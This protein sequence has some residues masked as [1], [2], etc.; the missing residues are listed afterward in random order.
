[1]K[2][3]NQVMKIAGLSGICDQSDQEIGSSI[4]AGSGNILSWRLNMKY[5]LGSFS[6]FCFFKKSNCQCLVKECAQVLVYSLEGFV[7]GLVRKTD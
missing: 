1:M 3:K 5:F 2:E 6:S 4:P 7:N